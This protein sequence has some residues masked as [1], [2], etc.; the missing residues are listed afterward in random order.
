[1]LCSSNAD[2][3]N[4]LT[5]SSLQIFLLN[6]SGLKHEIGFDK[7][8]GQDLTRI[9]TIKMIDSL[10]VVMKGFQI[11]RRTSHRK[12]RAQVHSVKIKIIW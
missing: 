3:I 2:H 5:V 12:E 6:A 1:M 8:T 9:S 11:V 4:L 10:L 7:R